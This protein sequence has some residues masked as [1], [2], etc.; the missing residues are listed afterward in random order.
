MRQMINPLNESLVR[1]VEEGRILPGQA[2]VLGT[3]S[4]AESVYLIQKGFDVIGIDI[5]PAAI[6]ATR[7]NVSGHG[8]FGF[9]QMGDVRNI[10]V[11]EN[12]VD[13]MHDTGCFSA[14][15]KEDR[16]QAASE[17]TRV[18]KRRSLILMQCGNEP[19]IAAFFP[20]FKIED[21]GPDFVLMRKK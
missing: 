16:V 21:H 8:L 2:L 1:G 11:E 6:R 13:F 7:E 9:F 20:Q 15:N 5:D 14:L 4:G 19:D 17:M 18:A 10:P 3:G 12:W